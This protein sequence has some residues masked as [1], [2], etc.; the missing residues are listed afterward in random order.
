[1]YF[2]GCLLLLICN[3]SMAF[4]L[5]W[6]GDA[7]STCARILAGRANSF[8]DF[9][10]T[11]QP[12][13]VYLTNTS[14]LHPQHLFFI[15]LVFRHALHEFED[16]TPA[17]LIKC[18]LHCRNVIPCFLIACLLTLLHLLSPTTTLFFVLLICLLYWRYIHPETSY[19]VLCTSAV[20]K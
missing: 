5:E 8:Q 20:Q 19:H 4:V 14:A 17:Q 2:L 9:E 6:R 18:K 3:Y 1:M 12:S 11:P 16:T 13:L 7:V 15:S 10:Q